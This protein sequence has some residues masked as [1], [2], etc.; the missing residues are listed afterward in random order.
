LSGDPPIA[1]VTFYDTNNDKQT[2]DH[3]HSM[4]AAMA[5]WGTATEASIKQDKKDP[6]GE[7]AKKLKIQ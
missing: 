3:G 6:D 7:K 5:S 2:Y 4:S 1:P